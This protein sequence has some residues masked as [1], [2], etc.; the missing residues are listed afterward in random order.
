MIIESDENHEIKFTIE[1]VERMLELLV[2]SLVKNTEIYK[3]ELATK[4]LQDMEIIIYDHLNESTDMLTE[5]LLDYWHN[6]E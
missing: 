2:Y 5:R 6:K 4:T 3:H 1:N